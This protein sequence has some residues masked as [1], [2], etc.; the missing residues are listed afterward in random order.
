MSHG[1]FRVGD[2]NNNYDLVILNEVIEHIED[3]L[4]VF[5]D[6]CTVLRPGGAVFISTL[7]TDTIINAGERSWDLFRC[8]WYKDD[9]THVSFYCQLTFEYL[10]EIK[11][12]MQLKLLTLA[13]NGAVLQQNS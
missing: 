10:C 3:V 6:L 4:P 11:G 8:W 12:K 7:M 2:Y 5:D 13:S 1:D 9:P